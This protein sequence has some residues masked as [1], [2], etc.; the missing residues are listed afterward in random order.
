MVELWR[1]RIV[2]TSQRLGCY[3]SAHLATPA[4]PV[5]HPGRTDRL[6]DHTKLA[7]AMAML[8]CPTVASHRLAPRSRPAA[9]VTKPLC[10]STDNDLRAPLTP[11]RLFWHPSPTR[12]TL[13]L[14]FTAACSISCAT[15]DAFPPH[16]RDDGRQTPPSLRSIVFSALGLRLSG[17]LPVRFGSTGAGAEL[18]LLHLASTSLS[19]W[20]PHAECL[21]AYAT[22]TIPRMARR[23]DLYAFKHDLQILA[24]PDSTA[25]VL[26]QSLHAFIHSFHRMVRPA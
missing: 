12:T 25:R 23:G 5:E 4:I 17:V 7:R 15:P 11:L 26:A 6:V 14:T 21:A 10:R 1:T 19:R 20:A 22:L 13:R 8:L 24:C 3:H 18:A 16:Q 9:F 2:C